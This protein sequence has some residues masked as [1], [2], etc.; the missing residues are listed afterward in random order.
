[1]DIEVIF[2]GF[3]IIDIVLGIGG[4]LCGCVVEIYGLEL[5]GKIMLIF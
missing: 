1:M 4:L 3:F 2:I 5:L